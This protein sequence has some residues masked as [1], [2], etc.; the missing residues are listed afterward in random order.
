MNLFYFG[1]AIIHRTAYSRPW[2]TFLHATLS[3]HGT[4]LSD[5]PRVP[6][7]ECF[8]ENQDGGGAPIKTFIWAG[9]PAEWTPEHGL[10]YPFIVAHNLNP[11]DSHFR[12][13]TVPG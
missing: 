8:A 2:C 5:P 7:F 12:T 9:D 13:V 10:L 6:V 1:V 11:T 3:L 4:P